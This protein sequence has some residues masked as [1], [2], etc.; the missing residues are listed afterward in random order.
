MIVHAPFHLRLVLLGA[1]LLGAACSRSGSRGP[2]GEDDSAG[3][4]ARGSDAT[5]E[6]VHQ[7]ARA[8]GEPGPT[9]DYV[10]AQIEGVVKARTKSQALIFYEGYRV[11]LT[12]PGDQVTQII[13][14]LAEAKPTIQQLSAAFGTPEEARK[15]MLYRYEAHATGATIL[16]LAEPVSMPANEGTLVRR[17]VL[18]GAR[19]R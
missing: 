7:A 19:I 2:A 12:T 3:Q 15:G 4:A 1:L 11:T 9:V 6:R 17:I 10:A 8:L 5:V 14:D 18:E 16:I 13:F